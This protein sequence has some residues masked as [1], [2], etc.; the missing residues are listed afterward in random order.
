MSQDIGQ[1]AGARR[2]RA[3]GARLSRETGGG[4][5]AVLLLTRSG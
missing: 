2:W 5:A 1:A 3:G 4:I